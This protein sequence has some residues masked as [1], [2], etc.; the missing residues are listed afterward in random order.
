MKDTKKKKKTVEEQ[1]MSYDDRR[2]PG[3]T[4]IAP[5]VLASIARLTA[6]ETPG[7]SRMGVVAAGANR[8]FTRSD[9]EGVRID[10]KGGVVDADIYLIVRNDVNIRDVS[11]KVQQGVARAIREMVGMKVGRVNVHIEDID[12]PPMTEENNAAKK[13]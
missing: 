12:Y 2:A 13:G 8:L 10:V 1:E 11:R 6:L 9:S 5:D 3:K 4:T 7:V